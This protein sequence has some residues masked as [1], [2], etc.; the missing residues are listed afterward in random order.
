MAA[1]LLGDLFFDERRAHVGGANGIAGDAVLGGL[2][3]DDFGEAE[4][5]VFRGDVSRFKR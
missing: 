3:S 5:A 4:D 1:G 2:E